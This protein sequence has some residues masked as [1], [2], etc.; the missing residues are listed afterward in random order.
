MCTYCT[1]TNYRKIYENHNG[2][3]PKDS[4]GR[5][6]EIHHID[7][8]HSNNNPKNLKAVT[9]QEHYDIHYAQGDF[10]ACMLMKLQRMDHSPS[11][12]IEL[13]RNQN[14]KRIANGTHHFIGDNNPSYIRSKNK[15]HHFLGSSMN[16]IMIERGSHIS[17][18][19]EKCSEREITKIKNKT[20][21]FIIANP[22]QKIWTCVHCNKSGK[23]GN[24]IHSRF[25]GD[26][27]K[28]KK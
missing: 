14:L 28:Q 1:T 18:H 15:T 27:C 26:N 20:H 6:Y 19:P 17:Q 7:G 16:D 12:I 3:I 21:N 8:N 23:G 5:T 2:I 4:D 11:E 25:H 10:G 22:S 9:L 13:N 24:S